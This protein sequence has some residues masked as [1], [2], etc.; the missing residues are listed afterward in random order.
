LAA[1]PAFLGNNLNPNLVAPTTKVFTSS[2]GK[3]LIA[4]TA[5]YGKNIQF[6][7]S[8]DTNI[9]GSDQVQ[10]VTPDFATSV[11]EFE[12]I[13]SRYTSQ[14]YVV[15]IGQDIQGYTGNNYVFAYGPQDNYRSTLF[16]TRMVADRIGGKGDF[17][18]DG[19]GD[20][21]VYGKD[22]IQIF[23]GDGHGSFKSLQTIL[24]NSTIPTPY[25]GSLS[26]V[27]V[28]DLNGDKKSDMAVLGE[29]ANG[30]IF[31][32]FANVGGRLL[33]K[34]SVV[35]E[36]SWNGRNAAY[37]DLV[38]GDVDNDK[39]DDI[40]ITG[41]A[42]NSLIVAM[43]TAQGYCSNG[44]FNNATYLTGVYGPIQ[45][46]IGDINLDGKADIVVLDRDAS[47]RLQVDAFFGKGDGSFF[48]AQTVISNE[49][50]GRSS[51]SNLSFPDVGF[52]SL[53]IGDFNGDGAADILVSAYDINAVYYNATNCVTNGSKMVVPVLASGYKYRAMMDFKGFNQYLDNQQLEKTVAKTVDG[54]ALYDAFTNTALSP[55][56]CPDIK[57]S[58]LP[59]V[60]S[61]FYVTY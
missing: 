32:S 48:D 13:G 43:G 44:A 34:E 22:S 30:E 54:G 1:G 9:S 40:V 25:N 53:N 10:V 38:A 49:D 17:N 57:I 14:P 52:T 8:S 18:G 11:F 45:A 19:N 23:K 41:N 12:V 3:D 2:A 35:L 50:L 29:S 39:R 15:G 28:C 33:Q 42:D 56:I 58:G 20:F 21:V 6:N 27:I 36:H 7:A 26:K 60:D 47:G 55:S 61:M 16:K 4:Y 31:T 24:P 46:R 51:F 59:A 37:V 5:Y